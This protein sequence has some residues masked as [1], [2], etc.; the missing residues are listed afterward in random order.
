MMLQAFAAGERPSGNMQ[1]AVLSKERTKFVSRQ[2][3]SVKNTIRLMKW[4]RDQQQWSGKMTFPSDEV[5]ELATIY[6]SIQTK[7]ADQKTAIANV[8]SLL[9]QFSRLRV[10]WSYFYNK[11]DVSPPLLR[12]RPLLMD[13]TNP[14]LNVADPQKFDATEL[15]ELARST[16]FF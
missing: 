7:P 3:A 13:P 11:D 5:L 1:M 9:S 16:H 14:Y 4:W 2:P 10:V 15:M 8:M 12:Q 6:S